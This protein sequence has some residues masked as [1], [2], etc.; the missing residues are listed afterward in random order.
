MRKRRDIKRSLAF[1]HF[2]IFPFGSILFQCSFYLVLPMSHPIL[3]FLILHGQPSVNEC[4]KQGNSSSSFSS[5]IVFFFQASVHIV[6]MAS[7]TGGGG[8]KTHQLSCVYVLLCIHKIMSLSQ[9]YIPF[10]VNTCA[11]SLPLTVTID[12]PLKEGKE[13]RVEIN[14]S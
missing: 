4:A 6:N 10:C 14:P 1:L 7:N 13:E 11:W 9:A 8:G 2:I 3:I 5:W 12:I